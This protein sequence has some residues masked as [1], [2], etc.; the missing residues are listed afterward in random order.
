MLKIIMNNRRKKVC[1]FFFTITHIALNSTAVNIQIRKIFESNAWWRIK[2]AF[3]ISHKHYSI[4]NLQRLSSSLNSFR[5]TLYFFIF[6]DTVIVS[7]FSTDKMW[8]K[9][10]EIVRKTS[11]ATITATNLRLQKTIF[12]VY[13]STKMSIEKRFAR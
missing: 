12:F 11:I 9:S 8:T 10:Y 4:I 7:A 3:E 1:C 13:N 6:I 5:F 2:R